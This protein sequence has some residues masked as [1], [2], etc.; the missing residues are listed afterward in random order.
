MVI[1]C[2]LENGNNYISVIRTKIKGIQPPSLQP[3]SVEM[4]SKQINTC[5]QLSVSETWVWAVLTRTCFNLNNNAVFEVAGIWPMTQAFLRLTQ[6]IPCVAISF[7]T[8]RLFCT[9]QPHP[10]FFVSL[11]R[12]CRTARLRSC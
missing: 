9:S 11:D 8:L 1:Q 6:A 12:G 7:G 5:K 10:A 4:A 3:G 2:K